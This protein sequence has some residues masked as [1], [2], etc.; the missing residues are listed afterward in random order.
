MGPGKSRLEKQTWSSI[1]GPSQCMTVAIMNFNSYICKTGFPGLVTIT[2]TQV[3]STINLVNHLLP[4][5][6]KNNNL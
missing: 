3:V 2:L 6:A 1:T 4:F 5:M